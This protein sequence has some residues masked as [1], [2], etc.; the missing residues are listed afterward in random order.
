MQPIEVATIEDETDARNTLQVVINGTPG[1]NCRFAYAN[2]KS[3]VAGIRKNPPDIVLVDLD[4][5]MINGIEC[6]EILKPEMPSVQFMVLT[7]SEDD[8]EIFRA[9]LAGA[10]SYILKGTM[11][12][13]ILENIKELYNG[14]SPMSAQIARKAVEFL[15]KPTRKWKNPYEKILTKRERQVV[16]LL[17]EGLSY[18]QIASELYVSMETVKSHCHNIYQKLQVSSSAQAIRKYFK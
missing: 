3:A 18:K 10:N 15:R 4:I 2:G 14:G 11:F 6:I 5:P 16:E 17:R 13:H 7:V 8:E 1:L 9:L 12:S